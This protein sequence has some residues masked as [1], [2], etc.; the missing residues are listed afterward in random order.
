MYNHVLGV[1]KHSINKS[2][3]GVL[4]DTHRAEGEVKDITPNPSGVNLKKNGDLR[5]QPL[6]ERH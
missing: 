3:Q 2:D 6:I 5:V 1:V 4:L